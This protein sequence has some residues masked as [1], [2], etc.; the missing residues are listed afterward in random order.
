[1]KFYI[2]MTLD[3][4]PLVHPEAFEWINKFYLSAIGVLPAAGRSESDEVEQLIDGWLSAD[5][6]ERWPSTERSS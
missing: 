6:T 1:M 3:M 2:E 5:T 4:A